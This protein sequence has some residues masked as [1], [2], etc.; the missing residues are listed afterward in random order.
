M[1]G[2][3]VVDFNDCVDGLVL[4]VLVVLWVDV[5]DWCGVRLWLMVCWLACGVAWFVCVSD[6]WLRYV[7]CVW[8]FRCLCEVGFVFGVLWGAGECGLCLVMVT[9]LV[10]LGF[11]DVLLALGCFC[12]GYDLFWFWNIVV[13]AVGG[14]C[15]CVFR[16]LVFSDCCS[17][18]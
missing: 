4:R 3:G 12:C 5:V 1:F 15:G 2:Y 11:D 10:G 8:C 17:M 7:V 18:A 16:L 14:F 6:L 13:R 9:I